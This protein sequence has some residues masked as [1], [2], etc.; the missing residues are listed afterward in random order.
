MREINQLIYN[1]IKGSSTYKTYTGATA[2]DPRIYK[3]RTPA[4]LPISASKPAYAVYRFVGASKPPDWIYGIQ[5]NNVSYSLEVYSKI[6]TRLTEITDLLETLF[7]DKQFTTLNYMIGYC[8][9]TRGSESWDEG[10]QLY[11]MNLT[12]DFSHIFVR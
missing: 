2:S 9:A 5:R 8:Y 1:T 6:D 3:Q 10:R 7:E 12:L 11:F 4:K